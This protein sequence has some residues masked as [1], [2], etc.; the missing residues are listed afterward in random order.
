LTPFSEGNKTPALTNKTIIIYEQGKILF[1]P[2]ILDSD[3]Q[4]EALWI[5]LVTIPQ[6]I[7]L[8]GFGD[9][10]QGNGYCSSFFRM[11]D[12]HLYVI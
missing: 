12:A 7:T 11:K 1:R 3:T 8:T 9:L 10:K 2:C 5:T 6:D 4:R